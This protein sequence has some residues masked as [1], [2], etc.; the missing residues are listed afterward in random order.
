MQRTGPASH[1]LN[2]LL[3]KS[4]LDWQYVD[5]SEYLCHPHSMSAH[6]PLGIITRAFNNW[7]YSALDNSIITFRQQCENY[8]SPQS[9]P[10]PPL[11]VQPTGL[12]ANCLLPTDFTKLTT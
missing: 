8:H 7:Y 3:R 11:V 9:S 2:V 12:T 4:L 10:F 1:T 6:L 5:G